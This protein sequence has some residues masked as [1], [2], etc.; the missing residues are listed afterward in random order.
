MS[1]WHDK[2]GK[3]YA[4]KGS[5]SWIKHYA[6]HLFASLTA[7]LERHLAG[8]EG[9]H[10][11][12]D[13]LLENNLSMEEALAAKVDKVPGMGLSEKNY[14]AAEKEKLASLSGNA[15]ASG[16]PLAATGGEVFNDYENNTSN[17]PYSHIEGRHNNVAV[18][19]FLIR[20]YTENTVT[21]DS[22]ESITVGMPWHVFL[23]ENGEQKRYDGNI[24]S[25]VG[26][27]VT[28]ADGELPISFTPS[29]TPSF[30]GT[31]IVNGG[32]I[33]SHEVTDTA[34]EFSSHVEGRS[35]WGGLDAHAEGTDTK[36]YGWS[37][38]AEGRKTFA[39][40]EISHAE[41]YG[42]TAQGTGSHVEGASCKARGIY[43]HAEGYYT[44]ANNRFAHAEGQETHAVGDVSHA[45]GYN[46]EAVGLFSHSEGSGTHAKGHRSHA[47]GDGSWANGSSSHAEGWQTYA[48]GDHSHAE[49]SGTHASGDFSHAEGQETYAKGHHSHA[50]GYMAHA[51]GERS[52]AEGYN[53]C[54]DG[55]YAHAEGHSTQ[56]N[57][58]NSH[59]EGLY[60]IAAS[61]SQHVQGKYNAPDTANVYA[62]IVGNGTGATEYETVEYT[63]SAGTW[64][65][66][67]VGNDEIRHD[68]TC[69][70]GVFSDLVFYDAN[71]EFLGSL[72]GGANQFYDFNELYKR[73]GKRV[74][75]YEISSGQDCTLTVK[76]TKPNRSNAYTLDWNG[77]GWFAG[78][79]EASSIVLRSS[80]EGSTKRFMLTVSD[81]GTLKTEEIISI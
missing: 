79:V 10:R 75:S 67:Y 5:S 36:A 69:S 59:V 35:N 80:T 13:V 66:I 22:T 63:M 61:E 48:T 9:K 77:N 20:S 14:T 50:E 81:D 25:V 4:S 53:T 32:S 12:E 27:I 62:D 42:G 52:H 2:N 76:I 74:A 24:V 72:P 8:T 30:L 54:T 41:G 11:A 58:W 7:R 31:F 33:G 60:T 73:F 70:S 15:F 29:A 43:S 71:G 37:S 38:H 18:K 64:K 56:A 28:V 44:E 39:V 68:L 78:T 23:M 16:L 57:G 21:L 34:G 3:T 19:T 47:E 6:E 40:G 26:K 46:T 49:G 1:I 17:I 55:N 45:E 51:N 65:R